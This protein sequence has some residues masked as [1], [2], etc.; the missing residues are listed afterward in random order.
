MIGYAIRRLLMLVPVFFAVSVV[1][2]LILHLIPGDPIDNLHQ[3]RLEPGAAATSSP[4][5]TGSTA[6]CRCNTLIWLGKLLQRRSWH[7]HRR[8]APGLRP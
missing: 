3:D 6:A 5:A 1:I 4:R 7:C 8:A 2:F